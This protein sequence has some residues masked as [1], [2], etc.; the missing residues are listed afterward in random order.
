MLL[1][2]FAM[3]EGL[4][5]IVMPTFNKGQYIAESIDSVLSQTYTDWELIV[6]D[7]GSTDGTQEVLRRYNDPRIRIFTLN[8]NRGAAHARNLAL[9]QARGR[10]VAF[11]DSDDLW[12]PQ[13]LARQVAFMQQHGYAFTYHAYE[14]INCRGERLHKKVWGKRKVTHRDLSLCCWMGCLTVMYDAKHIGLVQSSEAK[15]NDDMLLWREVSKKADCCLLKECMA[16]YRRNGRKT[17]SEKTAD[18]WQLFR[19]KAGKT[20]GKSVVE[21]VLSMVMFG[22]KKLFYTDYCYEWC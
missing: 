12:H 6:V 2:R 11:L 18:I 14:E 15:F 4:V 10:Y 22:S 20:W 19:D 3:A 8:A 17:L 7:D 16:S 21:F 5:S 13:K 1:G 9:R